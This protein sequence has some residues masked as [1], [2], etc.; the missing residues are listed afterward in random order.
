MSLVTPTFGIAIPFWI[1]V[2]LLLAALTLVVWPGISHIA[3]RRKNGMLYILIILFGVMAVIV[4]TIGYFRSGSAIETAA[5]PAKVE[6]TRHP[7]FRHIF[8]KDFPSSGG[9]IGQDLSVNDKKYNNKY[10][11]PVR[12]IWEAKARTKF[13]AVF[14]PRDT[15]SVRVC[16][17]LLNNLQK[18]FAIFDNIEVSER[19]PGGT[20]SSLMKDAIFS[21]IVY[22][23]MENDMSL[24]EQA[25]I[26]RA[27]NEAGI[28]TQFFGYA[29]YILRRDDPMFRE[30]TSLPA[31]SGK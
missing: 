3:A 24:S 1:R 12:I 15:D 23:Y 2:A 14:V 31:P 28:K 5:A 19:I 8:D 6:P 26:E 20:S 9:S 21:N 22:F 18:V 27:Y 30:Q 17:S 29:Y 13:L 16:I 7:T 10:V 4:G 11:L 25:E